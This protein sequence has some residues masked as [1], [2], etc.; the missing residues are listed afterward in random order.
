MHTV[1]GL[2]IERIVNVIICSQKLRTNHDY[3][4]FYVRI[5]ICTQKE[6]TNNASYI[7]SHIRQRNSAETK[8]IVQAVG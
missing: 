7:D 2:K 3:L 4:H 5:T 6:K 1:V 8:T